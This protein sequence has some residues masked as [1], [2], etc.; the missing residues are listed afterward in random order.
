M[1]RWKITSA[2]TQHA[3]MNEVNTQGEENMEQVT[4]PVVW[5][6]AALIVAIVGVLTAIAIA[7]NR[8]DKNDRKDE[9]KAMLKPGRI[10]AEEVR[11]KRR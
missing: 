4:A 8:K 7:I 9:R 10:A 11:R 6:I 2:S 5:G 3:T 1:T